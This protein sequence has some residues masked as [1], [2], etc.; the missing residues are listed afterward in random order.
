MIADDF[1]ADGNLDLAINTNDYG[2]DVSVGRYDALNGLML[3][4]D[5]KEISCRN[6]F[7]KVDF[8]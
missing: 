5:G 7:F 4:G 8:Y 1:D 2:T 6:L 3:K